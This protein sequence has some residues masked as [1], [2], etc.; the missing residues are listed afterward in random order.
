[1]LLIDS[2]HHDN[3]YK[4]NL[5]ERFLGDLKVNSLNIMNSASLSLFSTGATRGFVIEVG[6][7]MCTTVPVFEVI[8][9]P[10]RVFYGFL[11]VFIEACD[12]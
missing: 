3:K 1:V 10:M 12:A 4:E 6:H 2:P 5:I 7:G 11:G 9:F 8:L